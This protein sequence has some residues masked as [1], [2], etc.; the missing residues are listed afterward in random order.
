[1]ED[2]IFRAESLTKQYQR[3]GGPSYSLNGINMAIHKGDI[4]GFVGANGA[5]KTTLIRVLAGLVKQTQGDI[6][7]FGERKQENLYRQ[8]RRMN[9]IIEQ[10]ALDPG[11]TAQDNLK[12]CCIQRGIKDKE[13]IG[14][15]LEMAGLS[16]QE[17]RRLK[18]KNF[19]LG[20][21][22]RLG[23]AKAMLGNPEFVFFDEPLNGLDPTG[24]RDFRELIRTLHQRGITILISSHMLNE[25]DQIATCYG[26]I[27]KGKILEQVTAEDLGEKFSR[28][29]LIKV[30]N[31]PLAER[32]LREIFK[33]SRYQVVSG[34]TIH[35]YEQ[36][37]KKAKIVKAFAIKEIAV[38][39]ITIKGVDLEEYYMSLI[40]KK[41]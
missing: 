18:V 9:G 10:P 32:I 31:I 33:V 12:I 26:F 35:L 8:R 28:Y 36:L 2:I 41:K 29:M 34:D 6:E 24:I 14:E 11:L 3:F 39:E 23:V 20:M 37:D 13:C 15:V 17:I 25:L 40:R 4:Y 16:S 19:S 5:G 38:E 21:K 22:Q 1:M 7:L 30:D 27:H